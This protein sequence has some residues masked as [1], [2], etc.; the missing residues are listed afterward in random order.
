[1]R[2][3]GCPE[4][5]FRSAHPTATHRATVS[6]DPPADAETDPLVT[7]AAARRTTVNSAPP[8]DAETDLLATV[9]AAP[10][11]NA[12]ALP[13]VPARV[14]VSSLRGSRLSMPKKCRNPRLF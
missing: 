5:V 7:D 6:N 12:D 2:Q 11:A 3:S 8:A 1:M 14:S 10:P 4:H 9:A 13:K